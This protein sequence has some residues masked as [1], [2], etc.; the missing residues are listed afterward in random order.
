ML[1]SLPMYPY[2]P[3]QLDALWLALR[4]NLHRAGLDNLPT[5]LT[6]PDDYQQHWQDPHLLLSQS[7]GFPAV[8]LLAEQVG[9]IGAFHYDIPGCK[10]YHYSSQLLV[11]RDDPR[12]HLA[13]F[14]G[15]IA[16]CSEPHS[17]SGYHA[18]RSHIARRAL[19]QPFFGSVMF[20]GGHR[21]SA[22]RLAA[23]EA[24]IAA[25]DSVSLHLLAQQ[26]AQ[27]FS[28]LRILEQT[29]FT[30]G[31]PLI[32]HHATDDAVVTSLRTGLSALFADPETAHLLQ[33]MRI[34]NFTA[35]DG[36]AY[37]NLKLAVGMQPALVF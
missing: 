32:T 1:C 20:S 24:D 34:S 16:M 3:A 25:L 26:E 12:Q 35:L 8:N 6:L 22:R 21:H 23:G 4:K 13:D 9:I 18:L 5:Q 33:V 7:C 36:S 14:H 11:R 29:A 19:A 31:L 2:P 27:V 17:Q 28:R 15:G 37:Q 10:E 30:P